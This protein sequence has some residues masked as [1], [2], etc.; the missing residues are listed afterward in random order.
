[1]P[2]Y[3]TDD[4]AQVLMTD[5]RISEATAVQLRAIPVAFRSGQDTVEEAAQELFDDGEIP[6]AA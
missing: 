6:L 2:W 3:W 1:M 4:L 5:G